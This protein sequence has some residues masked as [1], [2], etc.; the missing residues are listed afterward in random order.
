M[1]EDGGYDLAVLPGPAIA[2]AAYPGYELAEATVQVDPGGTGG[3]VTLRLRQ[4]APS[5][6]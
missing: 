5:G 6:G 2:R 4:R 1:A 3:P